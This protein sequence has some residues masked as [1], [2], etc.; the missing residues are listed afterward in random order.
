M[1][2]KFLVVVVVVKKGKAFL[3]QTWASPWDSRRL[4]LQKFQTIGT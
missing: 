2:P 4:R 3:L 1:N